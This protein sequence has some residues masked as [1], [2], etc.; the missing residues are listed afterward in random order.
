MTRRISN[1]C[2]LTVCAVVGIIVVLDIASDNLYAEREY[3]API[4]SQKEIQAFA[5]EQL[6]SL[7]ERSFA[8]SVEY[9]GMILEDTEGNLSASDITKGEEAS[10]GYSYE[11]PAGQNPVASFHTHGGYDVEYDN[12]TPSL[13]DLEQ[14]I[15]DRMDGYIST[16]GGRFWHI[17]WQAER[18][19]QV[20]EVACLTQDEK[21][22]PCEGYPPAQEYNAETLNARID[23]DEGVC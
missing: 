10:C 2:L 7:Q 15:T 11:W 9:C 20:C 12:E 21:F 14:E 16:P 4:S 6:E 22:V 5:K 23:N 3:I 19:V 13:T 18:A 1:G 8:T 17:D